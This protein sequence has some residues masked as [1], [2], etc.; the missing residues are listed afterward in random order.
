MLHLPSNCN[1]IEAARNL[2]HF[3]SIAVRDRAMFVSVSGRSP[4][5]SRAARGR[6]RR[7]SH[8]PPARTNAAQGRSRRWPQPSSSPLT[9]AINRSGPRSRVTRS[10][11]IAY[12]LLARGAGTWSQNAL[13][14]APAC[15]RRYAPNW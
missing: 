11:T 14:A 8:T 10:S 15:G 2:G 3:S 7:D 13:T 1:P 9:F 5:W 12:T 6:H 4:E